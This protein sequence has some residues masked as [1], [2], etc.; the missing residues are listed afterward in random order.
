MHATLPSSR[1]LGL[2]LLPSGPKCEGSSPTS[3]SH[4]V[5]ISPE[6]GEAQVDVSA[7]QVLLVQL[8]FG[9]LSLIFTLEEHESVSGWSALVHVDGDITFSHAE[10]LEEVSDLT[11]VGREGK[12]THLD[13]SEA[14]LSVDEVGKTH[15]SLTTTTTTVITEAI[16]AAIAIVAIIVATTTSTAAATSTSSSRSAA[17]TVTIARVVVIVS[18]STSTTSVTSTVRAVI[19]TTIVAIL[20]GLLLLELSVLVHLNTDKLDPPAADML[21]IESGLSLLAI[22]SRRKQDACLTC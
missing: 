1:P 2:T 16:T 13:R 11:H 19:V 17:A 4:F 18:L 9:A 22:I 20:I 15:G 12:S 5:L 21:L 10:I 7:A 14:I 6:V 3:H 8:V